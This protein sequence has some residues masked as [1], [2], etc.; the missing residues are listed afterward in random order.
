MTR[1]TRPGVVPVFPLPDTVLFPHTILPLHVFEPRYRTMV[2][3]AMAGD[4]SIAIALL[5]PGWE[6]EDVPSFHPIGTVG[7]IS[8]LEELTDGRYLLNLTGRARVRFTELPTDKPYRLAMAESLPEGEV[9]EESDDVRQDKLDLLS[10]YG[11]LVHEL[12]NETSAPLVLDESASFVSAV[13]MACARL[14]VE[15]GIR[16]ELLEIDDLCARHRRAT[17][18]LQGVL[19]AVL[20]LRARPGTPVN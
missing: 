2:R 1:A 16:Q 13:N 10:S 8:E 11:Y 7:Y 12:Q 20:R 18:I 14:P 17:A 9:D 19:E 15:P 4:R 5:C 3:D 6:H